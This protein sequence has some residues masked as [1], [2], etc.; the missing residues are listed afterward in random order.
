MKKNL[1][2]LCFLAILLTACGPA[3]SATPDPGAQAIPG[4]AGA[5]P[6]AGLVTIVADAGIKSVR[7]LAAPVS[8]ADELGQVLPGARGA[9][10]GYDASGE[11]LLVEFSNVTGWIP[12]QVAQLTTDY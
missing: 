12:I 8:D 7:V 11:W 1:L 4:E 2:L 6:G 9:L 10:L 3:V 5:T